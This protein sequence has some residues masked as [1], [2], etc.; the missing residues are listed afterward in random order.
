MT[1][2]IYM[3]IVNIIRKLSTH[4][5]TTSQTQF[6]LTF[7]NKNYYKRLKSDQKLSFNFM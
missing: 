1:F 3:N 4:K 2:F 5:V 6:H 7:E